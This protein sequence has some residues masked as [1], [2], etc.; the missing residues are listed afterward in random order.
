MAT[1]A[2]ELAKQI[3]AAAAAAAGGRDTTTQNSSI[4]TAEAKSLETKSG[5]GNR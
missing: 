3:A 4:R 2:A 5:S 1:S